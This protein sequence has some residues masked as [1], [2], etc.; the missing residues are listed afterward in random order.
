MSDTAP[1][2]LG[3]GGDWAEV[4]QAG[5]PHIT[6]TPRPSYAP[7]SPTTPTPTPYAYTYPAPDAMST[8]MAAS[9]PYPYPHHHAFPAAYAYAPAHAGPSTSPTGAPASSPLNPARR[10]A[11]P[12]HQP[13]ARASPQTSPRVVSHEP[14]AP[15]AAALASMR[16]GSIVAGAVHEIQPPRR[17]S[18]HQVLLLTPFG[19][20]IP[21]PDRRGSAASIGSSSMVRESS[22]MVRDVPVSRSRQNSLASLAGAR[23]SPR[24]QPLATINSGSTHGS[25]DDDDEDEEDDTTDAHIAILPST[26]PMTR[27]NSVPVLSLAEV[28]LLRARDAELGISRG[29]EFAWVSRVGSVHAADADAA[30]VSPMLETPQLASDASSVASSSVAHTV[31]PSPSPRFAFPG[32]PAFSDPFAPAPAEALPPATSPTY[33]YSLLPDDGRRASDA[34]RPPRSMSTAHSGAPRRPSAP[35]IRAEHVSKPLVDE[36]PRGTAALPLAETP[37]APVRPALK[38]YRTSPARFQ[39][40]GLDV[41]VR[42]SL[43]EGPLPSTLAAPLGSAPHTASGAWASVQPDD[44]AIP[45]RASHSSAPSGASGN[46]R[47]APSAGS[48]VSPVSVRVATRALARADPAAPPRPRYESVDSSIPFFPSGLARFV[49]QRISDPFPARRRDSHPGV[50]ATVTRR[51]SEVV[52]QARAEEW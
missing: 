52:R 16:R 48:T 18:N 26:V 20:P 19:A 15:S 30:A 46:N 12:Q 41:V 13:R 36:S 43:G 6:T 50:L 42:D 4:G 2:D 29:Q 8:V 37:P 23:R 35:V 5:R 22:T 14:C 39:G 40:L 7:P 51:A 11:Q 25:D 33:H 10:H 17:L 27:S 49:A 32:A 45:Q 9:Y 3:G 47:T 28:A 24:S 31:A 34:P 1:D 38:R 44:L 21:L